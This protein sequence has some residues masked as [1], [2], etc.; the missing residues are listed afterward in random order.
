MSFN[1]F[2]R[3]LQNNILVLYFSLL[4]TKQLYKTNKKSNLFLLS[5]LLL[6]GQKE[7]QILLPQLRYKM[8][9]RYFWQDF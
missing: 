1:I 2:F 7:I 5:S 9:P 3:A 6:S 4:Q 8:L